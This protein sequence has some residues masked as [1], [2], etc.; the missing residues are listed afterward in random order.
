MFA[1]VRHLAGLAGVTALMACGGGGG[2]GGS[3]SYSPTSPGTTTNPGVNEVI[4]T[5]SNTFNPG[6]LTVTKGTTVTFT[7]QGTTHNVTFNNVTGA[8][9]SIPNTANAGVQRLFDTAGTFGYNCT[10][11]SGMSGTVVVN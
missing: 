2:N 8:P 11:H 5:T 6:T 10:I 3:S 9:A 1:T 7:F 4:A